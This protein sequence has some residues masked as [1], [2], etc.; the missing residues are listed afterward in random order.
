MKSKYL[1]Y[2]MCGII[3]LSFLFLSGCTNDETA[4]TS[5]SDVIDKGTLSVGS[6]IPYEPMEYYDEDGETVIGLDVDVIEYIVDG[7]GVTLEIVD[8][9]WADIFDAVKNGEVDVII[10]SITITSDRSEEMLFSTPYIECGQVILVKEDNADINSSSNLTGKKIGVQNGTTSMQE[11]LKYTDESLVF[12]YE[13]YTEYD[14]QGII[15]DLK[16]GTIDA[17]ITDYLVGAGLIGTDDS[18]K[19]VGERITEEYFG[20]ATKKGND[21]LIGE[22]NNIIKEMQTNG[23][24]QEIE[25]KW[26]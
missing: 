19:I 22:I 17:I 23:K 15:F 10:S 25:D 26:L 9:D 4:D 11:A 2:I 24:I 7:M 16:N 13:N 1:A 8:Y 5:L 21:A 12:T 18:L 20:I 3:L 6:D 14:D